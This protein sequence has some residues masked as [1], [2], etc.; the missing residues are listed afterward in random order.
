[1]TFEELVKRIA[2]K[3]GLTLPKTDAV[4]RDALNEAAQAAVDGKA[5]LFPGIGRFATR[6][7]RSKGIKPNGVEWT[8]PERLRLVLRTTSANAITPRKS[9]ATAA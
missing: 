9:A 4:I 6:V 3:H 2:V 1:M 7:A 8:R 5:P